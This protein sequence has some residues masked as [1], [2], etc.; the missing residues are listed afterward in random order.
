MLGESE[1]YNAALC[2]G[3]VLDVANGVYDSLRV[4]GVGGE[5]AFHIDYADR[6]SEDITITLDETEVDICNLAISPEKVIEKIT[7]PENSEMRILAMTLVVNQYAEVS[8]TERIML[9]KIRFRSLDGHIRGNGRIIR[10]ARKSGIVIAQV[11]IFLQ[12]NS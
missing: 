3:Q 5:G 11:H 4:M 12:S 7:L 2:S 1:G 10:L 6:T 8:R 9:E